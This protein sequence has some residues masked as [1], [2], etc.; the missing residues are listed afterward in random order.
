MNTHIFVLFYFMMGFTF[1]NT[2]TFLISDFEDIGF[3]LNRDFLNTHPFSE[4]GVK[5]VFCGIV[6][7][8]KPV[9]N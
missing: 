7:D 6:Y 1:H 4:N 9:Y 5:S 2:N 8:F 3:M